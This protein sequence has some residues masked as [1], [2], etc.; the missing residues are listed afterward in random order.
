MFILPVISR[1]Y[2][3]DFG[4][5]NLTPREQSVTTTLLP[6]CPWKLQ[7]EI[8]RGNLKPSIFHE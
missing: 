5:T 4:K 6:H 1:Q 3:Q 7:N 2:L 8:L